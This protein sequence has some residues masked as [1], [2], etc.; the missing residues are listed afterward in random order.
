MQSASFVGIDHGSA[1]QSN[2]CPP[3]PLACTTNWC[4]HVVDVCDG[5]PPSACA[6]EANG[7][8]ELGY[9]VG[10]PTAPS[11]SDG[12]LDG[13]MPTETIISDGPPPQ[14]PAWY[15][16]PATTASEI[17]SEANTCGSVFDPES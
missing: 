4:G 8:I 2:S 17:P 9:A 12:E 5:C 15:A 13:V 3:R 10:H 6:D 7:Q 11:P 14:N 1:T 16:C